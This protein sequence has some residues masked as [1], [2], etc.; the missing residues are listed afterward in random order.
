MAFQQI[1][2]EK[3][4]RIAYITINRPE[5]M[6]TLHRAANAEL[7]EAFDDFRRLQTTSDDFRRLQGR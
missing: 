4:G 2:Y 6:N 5:V 7:I 1:I 3:R